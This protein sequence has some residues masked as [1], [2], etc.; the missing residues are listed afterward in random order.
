MEEDPSV[1]SNLNLTVE[2]LSKCSSCNGEKYC[3]IT[4]SG[5]IASSFDGNN[6]NLQQMINKTFLQDADIETQCDNCSHNTKSSQQHFQI[7]EEPETLIIGVKRSIVEGQ[8]SFKID[9]HLKNTET[10]KL[11]SQ[12]RLQSFAT[13]IGTSITSGHYIAYFS[14]WGKYYKFDDI[15]D[16]QVIEVTRNVFETEARKSYLLILDKQRKVCCQA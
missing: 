7:I 10:I 15:A 4:E 2:L 12:Y 3:Q 5:I 13:H 1:Q 6:C 16:I 8:T 9:S 14:I 11:A